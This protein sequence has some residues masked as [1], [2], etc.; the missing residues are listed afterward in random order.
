MGC[1]DGCN[2]NYVGK[3]IR[4][5]GER[6]K[7]HAA[8]I[9]LRQPDKSALAKHCIEVEHQAKTDIPIVLAKVHNDVE[10]V[11]KE[12]IYIKSL[13][14]LMNTQEGHQG[15]NLRLY[16]RSLQRFTPR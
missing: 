5:V 3:T 9:R 13:P 11:N 4:N 12:A 7:E 15:L 1:Q 8:S 14:N 10:L 2:L 6:M 16:S